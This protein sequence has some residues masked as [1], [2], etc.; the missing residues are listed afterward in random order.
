MIRHT[1]SSK[2]TGASDLLRLWKYQNPVLNSFQKF[3]MQYA[4]IKDPNLH[5]IIWKSSYFMNMYVQNCELIINDVLHGKFLCHIW[6]YWPIIFGL[7]YWTFW[8]WSIIIDVVLIYEYAYINQLF[9][10]YVMYELDIDQW[11]WSDI[12][13]CL[14]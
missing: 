2:V 11:Y 10:V 1:R 8:H 13:K 9:R 7:S 3:H 14:L 6:V 4:L 12:W 5:F